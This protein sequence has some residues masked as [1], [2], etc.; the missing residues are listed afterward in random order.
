MIH[1]W[2]VQPL[3]GPTWYEVAVALYRF[4]YVYATAGHLRRCMCSSVGRLD[5]N[6]SFTCYMS[7]AVV[8]SYL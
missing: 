2:Y 1:T 6:Y 7:A 8:R 3:V 4:G 5:L